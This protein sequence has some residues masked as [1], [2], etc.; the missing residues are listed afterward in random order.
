MHN[1][2]LELSVT[3]GR[4]NQSSN[5]RKFSPHKRL[6]G[7][8]LQ[9]KLI[10][11]F[12]IGFCQIW[13]FFVNILLTFWLYMQLY[14]IWKLY[15]KMDILIAWKLNQIFNPL[16][17]YWINELTYTWGPHYRPKTKNFPLSIYPRIV[18]QLQYTSFPCAPLRVFLYSR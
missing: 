13:L 4:T 9:I 17:S 1:Q 3:H 11:W 16:S 6:D 12:Q 7:R 18:Y 5:C 2:R 10:N 15:S 14:K 8:S